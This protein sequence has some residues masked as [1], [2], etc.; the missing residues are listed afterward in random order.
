MNKIYGK[1][2]DGKFIQAKPQ[3]IDLPDNRGYTVKYI[4][5][6]D[7]A[8]GEF[9]EILMATSVPQNAEQLVRTGRG[10]FIHEDIREYIV[11]RFEIDKNAPVSPM[12][13]PAMT[14]RG[15]M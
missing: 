13:N 11:R 3:R 4:S 1:I 14:R 15:M 7:L 12:M 8:T 6:E 2:V 9:K 10:K 5:D